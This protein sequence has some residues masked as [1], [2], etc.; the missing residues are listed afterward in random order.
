MRRI[1]LFAAALLLP[2]A[3]P[4]PP[5]L[6]IG[7]FGRWQVICD[8]TRACVARGLDEWIQAVFSTL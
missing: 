1:P 6:I 4:L 2:A 7:R 8:N 3:A 5:V